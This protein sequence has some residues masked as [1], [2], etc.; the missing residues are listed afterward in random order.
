MCHITASYVITKKSVLFTLVQV[1][2]AKQFQF[3]NEN[4]SKPPLAHME[5]KIWID[6]LLIHYVDSFGYSD[7]YIDSWTDISQKIWY[8]LCPDFLAGIS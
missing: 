1:I 6:T 3:N 7:G 4:Y 2:L 5:H 8:K